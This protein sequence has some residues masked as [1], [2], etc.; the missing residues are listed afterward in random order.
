MRIVLLGSPTPGVAEQLAERLQLPRTARDD[1]TPT[2]F[3][4]PTAGFVL[5]GLPGSLAEAEQLD[6]LLDARAAS[7]DAVVSFGA[8][9]ELV[10]HY[11][12]RIVEIDTVGTDD[13]V[14]DRI[15]AGLREVLIAA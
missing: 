10:E 4:L 2:P 12:G 13:S 14:V 3:E 8:P 15:V 1:A 5:A 11:R 9:D 6:R 7:V